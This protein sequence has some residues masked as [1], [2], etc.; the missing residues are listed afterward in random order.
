[1]GETPDQL[2][3]D[4]EGTRADMTATVDAITD[5]T[6]PKR[7]ASRQAGRFRT[8]LGSARH[9]MMGNV[10]GLGDRL[11]GTASDVGDTVSGSAHGAMSRVRQGPRTVTSGNPLAAG[12]VA[13]AGGLL[14]ASVLPA[15][16]TE[17]R[18]LGPVADQ[19]QPL[20]EHGQQAAR[21][22]T[23]E[24]KSSAQDAA[25]EVKRSAAAAADE[26]RERASEA[27]G[28]AADAVKSATA[29]VTNQARQPS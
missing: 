5:R 10:N 23:N 25:Q 19:A 26:V 17:K 21:E 29:D 9:T 14:L 15:S 16:D 7:I 22:A 8:A 3:A 6:S 18:A 28:Q 12:L 2:R 13:F 11:S 4:I 27:S 20:I 24:L 1:M